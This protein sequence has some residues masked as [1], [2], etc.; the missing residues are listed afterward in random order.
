[1]ALL[2][3]SHLNNLLE[4]Q[5]ENGN[6]GSDPMANPRVPFPLIMLIVGMLVVAAVGMA[7]NMSRGREGRRGGL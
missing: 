4:R 6:F 5:N 1:M 7:V 3:L 2:P